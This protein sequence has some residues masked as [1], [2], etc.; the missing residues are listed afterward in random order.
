[1]C[2]SAITGV[3]PGTKH[4]NSDWKKTENIRKTE[5]TEVLRELCVRGEEKEE[6]IGQRLAGRKVE[7]RLR[8]ERG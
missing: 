7:Q 3:G 6:I 4:N 8:E 2:R 5:R 1:M